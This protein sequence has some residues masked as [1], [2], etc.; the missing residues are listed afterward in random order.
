[1]CAALAAAGV[2]ACLPPAWRAGR[3]PPMRAL[4]GE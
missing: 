3:V 1:V 4:R 2:L